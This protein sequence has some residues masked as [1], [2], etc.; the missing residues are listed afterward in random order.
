[1]SE[2]N[3]LLEAMGSAWGWPTIAWATGGL[4]LAGIVKG[5]TGLGYATCALPFLVAGLGLETAMAVVL[6]PALSTNVAVALT[7]GHLAETVQRFRTL[8]V[9]M[10]PGIAL[11][12]ALLVWISQPVAV[13]TLGVLVVAYVAWTLLRPEMQLSRGAAHHL[14][15]PVGFLNGVLTGLTGS[16]VMPLFPYMMALDLDAARLVQAIN[17]AVLVCSLIL[18]VGLGA[19]GIMTPGLL[20]LSGLAVLPAL[21]GVEIGTRLRGLIPADGFRRLVLLVLLLMGTSMILR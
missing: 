13:K 5:A 14:Q 9:S 16:Q 4:L 7:T 18:V 10:V 21:S 3:L 1:M 11:G 15:L 19:A 8:Y 6:L 12:I 20:G 17:F 2:L